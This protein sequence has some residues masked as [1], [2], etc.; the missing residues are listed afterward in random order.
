MWRR[1]TLS[2]IV[3]LAWGS[4]ESYAGGVTFSEHGAAATGKANA[5]AGEANDP[6]AI[7]YNPAGITQLP[8][9]QV[10]IGTSIVYLDTV[11]R[12]GT[13]G[14]STQ[15]QDQ[16]PIVPHFYITHRF[17]QWDERLSIGLGVYTP[18]GVV[19]DWPDNWQG[20]FDSTNAKLRTTIYN[21]VVA[22][23][24]TKDLSLAAGLRI[25]DV[26]AAFERQFA[27]PA[28]GIGES[29]LRAHD[30][31]A[32]P[33]G[34]NVGLLYHVTDTTSVGLQ[35]RS[36]LQAKLDG[37]AD[38]TGPASLAFSNTGFHSSIKLP[39][40][41]VAGIS[42]KIIP[43]WTINA[44]IEWEGWRT[45]GSLPLSFD[46]TASA[47]NSP[48]PRLW[49]NSY[50][51]RFGGEFAATDRIAIRGGYFYDQTPIPDN[52]FDPNIPNANLH[53]ITTGLGYKWDTMTLDVAYLIGFYEKRSIDG[54]T[55]DPF[56][57]AGPTSFGS[58]S[59]MPHVLTV[60]L[61]FKF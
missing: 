36:E 7:F 2:V 55:I 41:L 28:L 45:L 54:S 51:F 1:I 37:S 16:F 57:A 47:L 43:R 8:G 26:A 25:A 4:G 14:E 35:F 60:S 39:P 6:S 46:G 11:F 40:Q 29:K 15:L 53:A 31:T 13:T 50:V 23:Q 61:T 38:F 48:G 30:L 5:F 24:A 22:F 59:T 12:S 56:N 27:V 10:M 42:T 32:N 52:T 20:R 19:V 21:P 9:T 33:I 49:T 3:L 58:Y 17:K 18:F 44:D 34:W